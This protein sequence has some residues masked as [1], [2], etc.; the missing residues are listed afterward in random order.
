M[1]FFGGSL[2]LQTK[3]DMKHF[4][5]VDDVKNLDELI[6]L[7]FRY[8]KSPFVDKSS[9]KNRTVGLIFLNPSLRTR[10]STQK[11]AMHLGLHSIVINFSSE[12]WALETESGVIMDG[13]KPEHIIEAAGVVGTYFDIVAIR[14]FPQLQDRETDYRDRVLQAFIE[15]SGRP[16]ISLESCTRHPLQSLTDILTIR[17]FCPKTKPKVVLTWAPHPKALPQSVPNSFAEWIGRTNAEFTVTHPKG[18]EL[19]EQ[20]T[21]SAIIEYDQEK[22]FENA[23][24]IYAKNWSSYLDY[25]KTLQDES[26]MITSEKMKRTNGALFMHCLPLRRNVVAEDSVIDSRSSIVIPQAENRTF[27]AQAVLKKIVSDNL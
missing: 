4:T 15:Y 17:E 21:R 11:A 3:N 12:G 14:S 10:L 16:V 6:D 22:A 27:A 20:F 24:V 26:W 13:N 2:H 19:A 23:D 5:S 18:F 1:E 8:K 7:A 9:G 25:G